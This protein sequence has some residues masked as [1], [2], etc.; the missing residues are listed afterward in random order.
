MPEFNSPILQPTPLQIEAV[1]PQATFSGT[2]AAVETVAGVLPKINE[3]MQVQSVREQMTRIAEDEATA[4]E[5]EGAV[6]TPEQEA[7]LGENAASFIRA[8]SARDQ[9]TASIREAAALRAEVALR[10][11]ANAHPEMSDLFVRQ[12]AIILGRNPMGTMDK[13]HAARERETA[14]RQQQMQEL[15]FEEQV[16]LG[17]LSATRLAKMTP[18]QQVQEME[19]VT[20]TTELQ[21]NLVEREARASRQF[22]AVEA[23]EKLRDQ[24]AELSVK[25]HAVAY[26]QLFMTPIRGPINT[27][28]DLVVEAERAPEANEQIAATRAQLKQMRRDLG[29]LG[30][31]A[32]IQRYGIVSGDPSGID[33]ALGRLPIH[34]LTPFVEDV[35]KEID[36]VLEASS[37]PSLMAEYSA[38]ADMRA[39]AILNNVGDIDRYRAY[40]KAVG[41]INP[42]LITADLQKRARMADYLQAAATIFTTVDDNGEGYVDPRLLPDFLR[43]TRDV[44]NSFRYGEITQGRKE[45]APEARALAVRSYKA[46]KVG[47]D[48]LNKG[49][50]VGETEQENVDAINIYRELPMDPSFDETIKVMGIEA[51]A[52]Y[53]EALTTHYQKQVLG[54]NGLVAALQ[55]TIFDEFKHQ[56]NALLQVKWEVVNGNLMPTLVG[57]EGQRLSSKAAAFVDKFRAG[58]SKVYG[59]TVHRINAYLESLDRVAMVIG[60]L[61][62][63]EARNSA[64]EKIVSMLNAN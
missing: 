62:R 59:P 14:A 1:A 50:T 35:A 55:S 10:K 64:L 15:W 4:L 41:A 53:G 24:A 11:A 12:A 18:E 27:L 22:D 37:A 5:A 2:A 19:I 39:G 47:L 51:R 38:N 56:Q 44:H 3:Q 33:D 28:A 54:P 20:A 30:P 32:W 23:E 45:L 48:I 58:N 6:L 57:S 36:D 34:V 43:S 17:G 49:G 40:N 29:L 60:G 42:G 26:Q 61:P 16:A 8:S 52:E 31:R 25:R 7:R 13:M 9:G 63:E 46:Q 21:K